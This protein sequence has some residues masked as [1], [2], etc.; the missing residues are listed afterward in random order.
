MKKMSNTT[1]MKTVTPGQIMDDVLM[2]AEAHAAATESYVK[3]FVFYNKPLSQWS[4]ELAVVVPSNPTPEQMRGLY[5]KLA[6]NI[7]VASHFHS[8]AS[9][10]NSTLVG[11]GQIKQSDLVKAIVDSYA[12]AKATRPAATIIEEMAKSYMRD[13]TS[14]RVAAKVVK[15][16]WKNKVDTLTE[17]RKCMEQIGISLTAEMKYMA[18]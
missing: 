11:G 2:A 4:D 3:K 10:I 7:Q 12:K 8:V 9:T 5:V 6:N 17:V 13:T 18:S 16:F 15:D 14:T 1:E